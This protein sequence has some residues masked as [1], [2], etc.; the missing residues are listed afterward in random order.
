MIFLHKIKYYGVYTLN[1]C[2]DKIELDDQFWSDKMENQL[3]HFYKNYLLAEIV[4]SE[5][6]T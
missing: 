1:I 2:V 5:I 3:I 4:Q 6:I